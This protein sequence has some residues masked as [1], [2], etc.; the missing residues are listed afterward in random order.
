M[1]AP[2]ICERNSHS[3]RVVTLDGNPWFVA[4]DV[5]RALGGKAIRQAEGLRGIFGALEGTKSG[6]HG[7]VSAQFMPLFAGSKTPA[8]VLRSPLIFKFFKDSNVLSELG[9]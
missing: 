5:C 1:P 6:Q 7:V 4:A 2:A 9:K 8:A 3:I